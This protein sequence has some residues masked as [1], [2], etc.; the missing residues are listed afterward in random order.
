MSKPR[1]DAL[2]SKSGPGVILYKSYRNKLE[3]QHQVLRGQ[4]I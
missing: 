1:P 4:E 2:K 3:V